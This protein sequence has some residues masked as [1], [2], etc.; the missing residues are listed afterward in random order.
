[1]IEPPLITIGQDLSSLSR[2][3]VLGRYDT[4]YF[5]GK[6]FS[7]PGLPRNHAEVVVQ[8]NGNMPDKD[9]SGT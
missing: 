1:M 4:C 3:A 7:S 8:A 2:W 9:N 5:K 6:L